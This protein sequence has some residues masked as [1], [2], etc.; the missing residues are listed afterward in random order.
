MGTYQLSSL[1][2]LFSP[3]TFVVG[4]KF[5]IGLPGVVVTRIRTAHQVN[6][7][8]RD[9]IDSGNTSRDITIEAGST[10]ISWAIEGKD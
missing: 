7:D 1:P 10:T 5:H 3:R 6:G 4:G 9:Y 8:Y 2:R